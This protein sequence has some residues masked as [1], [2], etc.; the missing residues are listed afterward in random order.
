M[1]S[2]LEEL[3]GGFDVRIRY[4]GVTMGTE[5]WLAWMVEA[6]EHQIGTKGTAAELFAVAFLIWSVRCDGWVVRRVCSAR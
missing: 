2:E 5:A 3:D 6:S 1:W 4:E